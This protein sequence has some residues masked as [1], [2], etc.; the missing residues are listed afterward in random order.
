VNNRRVVFDTSTLVSAVLIHDSIPYRAL[1]LAMDL[2]EVCISEATLI[3]LAEVLMRPKFDRR[4]TRQT[5]LD[6]LSIIGMR[7]LAIPVETE[8]EALLSPRC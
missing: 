3:E 4:I 7:S 8:G 1:F 6:F 2:H 5:R